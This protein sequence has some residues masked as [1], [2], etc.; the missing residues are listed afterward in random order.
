MSRP[1]TA[2]R[3]GRARSAH[4]RAVGEL[5]AVVGREQENSLRNAFGAAFSA[6]RAP[7]P[8]TRR[9]VG[10]G[11][12]DL[13]LERP[14]VQCE[15]APAVGLQAEHRVHLAGGGAL[16]PGNSMVPANR[17]AAPCDVCLGGSACARLVAA[18]APQLEAAHPRVA[19]PIHLYIWSTP[20]PPI[21]HPGRRY[22]LGRQPPR[23]VGPDQLHGAL[24]FRLAPVD[25]HPGFAQ[26]G[27]GE[28]LRL[29]AEYSHLH[30]LEQWYLRN[31]HRCSNAATTAASGRR[32]RGL[33]ARPPLFGPRHTVRLRATSSATVDGDRRS[34][35][36]ICLH[37]LRLSRPLSIA[38][39][40]DLSSLRYGLDAFFLMLSPFSREGPRPSPPERNSRTQ[41]DASG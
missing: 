29:A 36:A 31:L 1:S 27:V 20:T 22:L 32:R 11:Q 26:L 21:G 40:S 24:E 3:T 37:D 38:A 14:Q 6:C 16:F 15:Q 9:L 33:A 10:H 39:R 5:G 8:S 28:R 7:I 4:S 25:A 34:S 19:A 2:W 13:E 12:R 35:R 41:P 17:R 23:D 30:L 18:P